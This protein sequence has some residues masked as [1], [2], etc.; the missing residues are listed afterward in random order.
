MK[1]FA[2]E[3]RRTPNIVVGGSAHRQFC[4]DDRH[5]SYSTN[6]NGDTPSFS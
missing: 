1:H 4:E 2:I 5:P 3:G 6:N